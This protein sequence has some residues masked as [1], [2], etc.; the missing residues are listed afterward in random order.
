MRTFN[1]RLLA[2]T[3]FVFYNVIAF[4]QPLEFTASNPAANAFGVSVNSNITVTFNQ[5]IQLPTAN[6]FYVYSERSGLISGALSVTANI[7]AFDPHQNFRYG[8]VIKVHI[9]GNI[10]T[11]G[12]SQLSSPLVLSFNVSTQPSAAVPP[13]FKTFPIPYERA[14]FSVED[15]KAVDFDNDGDIDLVASTL[16]LENDGTQDF[17]TQEFSQQHYTND[18]EVVDLDL[19]SD[20][21]VVLAIQGGVIVLENDGNMEFTER[22]LL[23]TSLLTTSLSISDE[24]GDGMLDILFTEQYY[25]LKSLS[26]LI[27]NGDN[28][29]S[30]EVITTTDYIY[31]AIPVDLDDDGLLD[32]VGIGEASLYW[33]RK[34]GNSYVREV[35]ESSGSFYSKVMTDDLDDDNDLDIL[36]SDE[37]KIMRIENLGS[38][39]F[40][41]HSMIS[42][43]YSGADLADIADVDG[44]R[45][46]D[47]IFQKGYAF[48]YFENLGN[49]HF[50]RRNIHYFGEDINAELCQDIDSD[51]DM[52]IAYRLYY[53]GLGWLK[54]TTLGEALPFQQATLGNLP[55]GTDAAAW[56]DYDLDGDQDVVITAYAYPNPTTTLY[57]N[58]SGSLQV[59]QEFT[60]LFNGN[61]RW[62]DLEN[63]GDPDFLVTGSTASSSEGAR[64]II[65]INDQN[66]FQELKSSSGLP[67]IS[68]GQ[69]EAADLNND[70]LAEI[71]LAGGDGGVYSF[72]GEAFKKVFAFPHIFQEGRVALSDI[73]LDGDLD[74]ALTGWRGNDELGAANNIYFNE[75]DFVFTTQSGAFDGLTGGSLLLHDL[76][77]DA[78]PDLGAIGPH[79]SNGGSNPSGSF[80][81]NDGSLFQKTPRPENG[82][83]IYAYFDGTATV[84][85]FDND[86]YADIVTQY[87]SGYRGLKLY[88]NNRTDWFNDTQYSFPEVSSNA[89]FIEP[90]DFDL[91]RDLDFQ[92]GNIIVRNN[93]EVVNQR[94]LP[95]GQLYDSVRN[96]ILYTYWTGGSDAETPASGLTYQVYIGTASGDQDVVASHANLVTGVQF[97]QHYGPARKLWKVELPTGGNFYWGVQAIDQQRVASAFSAEKMVPVIF[98]DGT[99]QSCTKT[100]QT[101]KA[102]PAGTYTWVVKGGE[103][104]SSSSDQIQIIWSAEGHG[105]VAVSN[106]ISHNALDIRI[107]D[108]P[109]PLVQGSNTVCENTADNVYFSSSH[110]DHTYRWNIEGGSFLKASDS[111]RVYVEWADRGEGRMKVFETSLEN[112]CTIEAEMIVTIKAKPTPQIEGESSL[113]MDS[114]AH[115]YKV[116][117]TDNT[118]QWSVFG[119]HIEG[120][121]TG[122]EIHVKWHDQ[123]LGRVM[124]TE[125]NAFCDAQDIFEVT[126]KPLIKPDIKGQFIVC[127]S[128]GS[129]SYQTE[130]FH[131]YKY[132]WS[133]EGGTLQGSSTGASISVRW[134]NP[135]TGK[136]FLRQDFGTCSAT[137]SVYVTVYSPGNADLSIH[138]EGNLLAAPSAVGYQ[139]LLNDEAIEGATEQYLQPSE[140]GYYSVKVTD[141]KG[142]ILESPELPFPVTGVEEYNVAAILCYPSPVRDAFFIEFENSFRGEVTI[143]LFDVTGKVL[144]NH[145][146]HKREAF[147]QQKLLV[148]DVSDGFIIV[149]VRGEEYSFRKKL[150]VARK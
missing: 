86:G 147:F 113:C 53:G 18:L 144:I 5:A 26:W 61:C 100:P 88:R 15:F 106:G 121:D 122:S 87:G 99:N 142:C 96:N 123:A 89:R 114:F 140:P 67:G 107:V 97:I 57:R 91:D 6:D 29:F 116:L 146:A 101:Y 112:I 63:D 51:G 139:W 148:A 35:L 83:F 36:V 84:G 103:I 135:G 45:D 28:S 55:E 90:V 129:F 16:W 42:D 38:G 128:E 108:K 131:D 105:S 72:Q 20:M 143:T 69:A 50:T 11:A 13:L 27:N 82:A 81:K 115:D 14:T 40:S 85:D 71:I 24:N 21:D 60:G 65:Y 47:I 137:D 130:L 68:S 117:A 110:D 10:R 150:I 44:D 141:M 79:R 12:G 1:Y 76:D 52:D 104:V 43:Q 74:M 41:V 111:S 31:R 19:D 17:A 7:L 49:D 30:R 145:V 134:M 8:D 23:S 92:S 66:T 93:I 58:V 46:P 102:I 33:Y 37:T 75:G 136:I 3:C 98:I 64:T 22:T 62:F 70:G 138:L 25:S 59:A 132:A 120:S 54:N 78:D 95:P 2:V 32:V 73:D 119:G 4:T 149:D 125:T 34:D 77:N 56:A 127:D 39:T 126:L 48:E 118:V 109:Q 94:P 133:A 124:V 9:T 80:Y